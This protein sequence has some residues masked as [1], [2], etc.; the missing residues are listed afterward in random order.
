[1]N[2]HIK[3]CHNGLETYKRYFK[4]IE[5]FVENM[6]YESNKHIPYFM[7]NALTEYTRKQFLTSLYNPVKIK[8]D[9]ILKKKKPKR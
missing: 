4:L 6:N 9:V 7:Y 8:T 3:R 1:M 2:E 5:Q